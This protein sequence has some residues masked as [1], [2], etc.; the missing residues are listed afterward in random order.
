MPSTLLPIDLGFV[1]C[2]LVQTGDGFILVD[3]GIPAQRSKVE[4]ALAQA[5]CE[6]GKLKLIVITHGDI[7]HTGGAAHLREKYAS[8]IAM[9]PLDAAMVENGDL[10]PQRKVKSRLMRLM[11]VFMRLAGGTDR[12]AANFERFKPDV[13]LEDGQSLLEYGFDATVL[14]LPG[15]TAGSLALLAA[16]GDLIAGDTLEN[17]RQP[18]STQIVADEAALAASLA[19]LSKLSLATIYPGHGRPFEWKQFK[20]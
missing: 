1:N 15:H 17:R 5:G 12:L 20:N 10:R 9:H 14:H 16:N 18:H 3:T 8:R 11:H 2:Y 7:D 13:L 19:R 4:A 6:P